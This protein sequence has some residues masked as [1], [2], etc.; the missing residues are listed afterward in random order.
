MARSL[1]RLAT[2]DD[3][4]QGYVFLTMISTLRFF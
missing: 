2:S 3:V 4:P 1:P